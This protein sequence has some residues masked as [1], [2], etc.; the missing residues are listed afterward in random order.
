MTYH[1]TTCPL[2]KQTVHKQG[3]GVQCQNHKGVICMQHCKE[4]Q[5][6]NNWSCLYKP[7][8]VKKQ[9]EWFYDKHGFT[10]RT[11]KA[12]KKKKKRWIQNH[13]HKH[14]LKRLH[15]SLPTRRDKRH[16]KFSHLYKIL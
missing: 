13:P 5:Y 14:S 12:H 9:L 2:C 16:G 15:K 4:C 3:A 6:L 1:N 10:R 8:L 7:D 11:N